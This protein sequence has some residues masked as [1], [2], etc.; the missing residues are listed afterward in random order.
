MAMKD[1]EKT[2]ELHWIKRHK[3]KRIIKTSIS[4]DENFGGQPIV[5]IEHFNSS[6]E[7]IRK[8]FK[9]KSQALSY[10]KQYMRRN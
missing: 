10:A 3:G 2:G 4:V 8:T 1:W 7:D 9:T 6:L 5:D